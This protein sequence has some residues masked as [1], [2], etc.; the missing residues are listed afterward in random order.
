MNALGALP[1]DPG[2]IAEPKMPTDVTLRR[3]LKHELL[4]MVQVRTVLSDETN[5]LVGRAATRCALPFV[6]PCAQR[7][8]TAAAFLAWHQEPA[9]LLRQCG[10]RLE[11]YWKWCFDP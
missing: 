9:I 2:G 6:L 5:S 1:P 7:L 8:R 11:A 4:V 10:R 3:A